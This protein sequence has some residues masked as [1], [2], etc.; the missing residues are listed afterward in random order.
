[1]VNRYKKFLTSIK[2]KSHD[3]IRRIQ[4]CNIR[5]VIV[6]YLV[7]QIFDNAFY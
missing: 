4:Q 6:Y 5:N 7:I 2:G 1:M 3:K